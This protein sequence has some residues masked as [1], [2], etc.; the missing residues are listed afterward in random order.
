MLGG[1]AAILYWHNDIEWLSLL[2]FLASCVAGFLIWNWPPARIFMGDACSGFLGFVLGALAVGTSVNG[3][4]TLWGWGI[5][6]GVFFVDATTTLLVR[7]FR[8]EKWYE[9]HRSHVYQILS[10]RFNS[11]S[12]ITLGVF[13]V[14]IFWLFPLA[15]WATNKPSVGLL[16]LV[17][18]WAPIFVI[19]YRVGAGQAEFPA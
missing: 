10:R 1:A 3:P 19:A 2:F 8:R 9:P 11:H 6:G 5:L 18:A 7:M 15:L 14:N 4:M 13:L 17:L 12:K 16:L